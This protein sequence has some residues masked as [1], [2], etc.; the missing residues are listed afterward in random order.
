M[1]TADDT[2][3]LTHSILKSMLNNRRI[4]LEEGGMKSLQLFSLT[5]AFILAFAPAYV[6]A[7][8]K[9]MLDDC[10]VAITQ[11]ESE[12]VSGPE[13]VQYAHCMGFLKAIYLSMRQFKSEDC[14][15]LI[16]PSGESFQSTELVYL[17]VNYAKAY[18]D[19]QQLE[20]EELASKAFMDAFPCEVIDTEYDDS[21]LEDRESDE[22]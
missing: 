14:E 15:E 17:F 18:P 12:K 8:S 22:E 1:L 16:C 6:S 10:K 19:L 3:N 9:D 4:T 2:A 21:F 20:P 11:I 5:V 7:G 13:M